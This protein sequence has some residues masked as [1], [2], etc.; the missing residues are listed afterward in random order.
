MATRQQ[1]P[2]TTILFKSCFKSSPVASRPGARLSAG[3]RKAGPP[4]APYLHHR[5]TAALAAASDVL[6]G[7]AH[8]D[9]AVVGVSLPVLLLAAGR[10]ADRARGRPRVPARQLFRPAARV[11]ARPH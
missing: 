3:S 1:H 4:N 8:P 5:R 9:V 7:G 10:P 2:P 11:L 6:A